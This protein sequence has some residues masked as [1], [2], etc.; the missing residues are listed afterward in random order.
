MANKKKR[1][2]LLARLRNRY[3]L[4]ILNDETFEEKASFRLSRLN[5]Y[6]LLSSMI[7]VIA[8]IVLTLIA[9]TPLKVYLLG[10]DEVTI[11][12]QLVQLN[13]KI[14]DLEEQ[15][16]V[17]DYFIQN[18]I[19]ITKGNIDTI[20]PTMIKP[21]SFDDQLINND[22]PFYDAI[23]KDE[24]E[25]EDR[26]L[27]MDKHVTAKDENI[28]NLFLFTPIQG[29]LT[30]GFDGSENHYGVDVVAPENSIVKATLDGTVILA[31]WT[32]ETGYVIGI[33]HANNL[34]SFYKHN[35]VLLKKIGNFVRAGDVIAYIGNTGEYTTGTHL[36][37]ELW[38]NGI[39][40]DPAEYILFN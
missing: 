38:Y 13:L 28:A 32:L 10:Y 1:A 30:N 25:E 34:T 2:S 14:D 22:K 5:I 8:G 37:F 24:F 39:A 31:S 26:D 23:L 7:V 36:H 11:K 17:K 21:E 29:Y 35:S 18:L 3:R 19:N 40:L 33:Q 15:M 27:L 12:E 20:P 16:L 6:V 4:V 9:F